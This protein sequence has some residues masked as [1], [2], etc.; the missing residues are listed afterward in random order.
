[1]NA[2]FIDIKISPTYTNIADYKFIRR[3]LLIFSF[4][5]IG[6]KCDSYEAPFVV[7]TE[8]IRWLAKWCLMNTLGVSS[9]SV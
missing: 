8:I 5:R 9:K 2:N 1:M 7:Y 4:I 3:S 6:Q